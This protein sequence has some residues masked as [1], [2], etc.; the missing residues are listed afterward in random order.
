MISFSPHFLL[1]K[2]SAFF[3][4]QMDTIDLYHTA[5]ILSPKRTKR[6]A[7]ARPASHWMR[8]QMGKIFCFSVG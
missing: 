1:E 4:A 5:A 6:F 2:Y 8:G 3:L 7:F